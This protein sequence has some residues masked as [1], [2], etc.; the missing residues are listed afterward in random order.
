MKTES[1][2]GVH[3]WFHMLVA[4]ANAINVTYKPILDSTP[5]R[6]A[7][8]VKKDISKFRTFGCKAIMYLEDV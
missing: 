7:Y 1:G 8:K 4:A 3:F 6:I 5:H 2:V